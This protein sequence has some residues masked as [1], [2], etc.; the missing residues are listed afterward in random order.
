MTMY[1]L[2]TLATL[3]C[4]AL[5]LRAGAAPSAGGSVPLRLL[6][7]DSWSGDA[8]SE[9]W[10]V[11]HGDDGTSVVRTGDLCLDVADGRPVAALCKAGEPGQRWRTNAGLTHFM[12]GAASE[13]DP[14]A[15]CLS[16]SGT[17]YSVGPSVLLG[18]CNP[19]SPPGVHSPHPRSAPEWDLNATAIISQVRGCCG[20]IWATRPV[21]LALDREPTCAQLL[22]DPSKKHAP[23]CNA[24]LDA[25][26]RARALIAQMT[27]AEKAMNMDSL[28]FGVPRLGVPPNTFSEALHGMCSAC[29]ESTAGNTGCPTSFPQ[30]I[31]MGASWNRSLWD[32]VGRAVSDELRGLYSQGGDIGW[33]SALFLWAP[34]INPFRDP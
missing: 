11:T 16:V 7:C 4:A 30:V 13:D 2:L 19:H 29:G 9:G 32:A 34:N 25:S 15:R 1:V 17:S 21:C 6:P 23:W 20:D 33:E 12:T 8:T 3:L 24:S 27:L 26:V 28:G 31:S 22:R 14:A 18:E 5:P 10:S